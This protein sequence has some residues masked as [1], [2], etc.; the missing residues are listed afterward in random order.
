IAQVHKA[1][2]ADGR[3][4]AVKVLR[5]GIR[6]RFARDIATYEWAAAHLEALGGEAARL[7]PRLTIEN[8]KRWTNRELDMRR[9]AA[10]A[11]ELAEARKAFEGYAIPARD[12]D[13]TNGRVMT[14]DWIDGI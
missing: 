9:E 7:R 14:L 10:S 8:F 5:P 4:V 2:T 6:R 3:T 12:W 13:R 1:V 11:S